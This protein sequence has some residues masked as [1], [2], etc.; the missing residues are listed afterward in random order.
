ME[1]LPS[2]VDAVNKIKPRRDVY[3]DGGIRNGWD[4]YKAIAIGAKMAFIG[5]PQVF[6]LAK[7]VEY[8]TIVALSI[9]VIYTI[10]LKIMGHIACTL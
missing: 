2:I 6:G 8:V 7:E 10:E 1:V 4:V 5:R 3:V 9:V